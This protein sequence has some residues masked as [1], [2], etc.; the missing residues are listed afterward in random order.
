MRITDA[1]DTCSG[2]EQTE[3]EEEEKEKL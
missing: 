2:G 1:S 3:K